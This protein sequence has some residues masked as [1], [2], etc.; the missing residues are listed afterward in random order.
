MAEPG[1]LYHH[2]A[3]AVTLMANKIKRAIPNT[4]HSSVISVMPIFQRG[5]LQS[6]DAAPQ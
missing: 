2:C 3:E 1:M 6:A 5:V 4:G